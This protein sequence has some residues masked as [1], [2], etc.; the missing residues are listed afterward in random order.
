MATKLK[1]NLEHLNHSGLSKNEVTKL[2]ISKLRPKKSFNLSNA[3]SLKL[4]T[5]PLYA[6]CFRC[7]LPLPTANL[8]EN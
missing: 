7:F 6:E 3:N 4:F 5:Q 2:L 8:L 1:D